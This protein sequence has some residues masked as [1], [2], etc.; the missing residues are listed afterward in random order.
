MLF[1]SPGK[2]SSVTLRMLFLTAVPVI[3]LTQAWACPGTK[4]FDRSRELAVIQ[5]ALATASLAPEKRHEAERLLAIA[6]ADRSRL[7][8]N[9]IYLQDAARRDAMELL[10][11]VRV[12]A[13]P[14]SFDEVAEKLKTMR[15]DVPGRTKAA[16]LL[17]EAEKLW[18]AEDYTKVDT[19]LNEAKSILGLPF[20]RCG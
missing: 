17:D 20:L 18:L 14:H 6:A 2:V 3:V 12:P 7:S 15:V 1:L 13:K 10:G 16:A 11:L 9:G 5:S 19:L 4:A 8:Y